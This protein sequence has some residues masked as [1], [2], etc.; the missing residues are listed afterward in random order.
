MKAKLALADDHV[1]LR[2]GLAKLLKSFDYRIVFEADNGKD[3]IKKIKENILPDVV[4]MDINMPYMDGFATSEWL[5]KN[6]PDIKV[7][8]LSMYDDDNSVVRMIRAGAKGYILKDAEPL[9][10]KRAIES[11][12]QQDFYHSELVTGKLIRSVRNGSDQNGDDAFG[13][14][15]R[16][17]QFLKLLCSELTYKEIAEQMDI[18]TRTIESYRDLIFEKLNVSTRI[19]AV[20]FAIKNRIISI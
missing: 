6:Y 5:K 19:G 7:L 3:F 2:N 14:T 20:I 1:L 9:E 15:D 10:L 13:L 17:I 18:K 12:L 8:A 11:V 16:E 4:L